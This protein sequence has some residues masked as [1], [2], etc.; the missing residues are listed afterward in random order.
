MKNDRSV[1]IIA[2]LL[3][4]IKPNRPL[5]WLYRELA[6]PPKGELHSVSQFAYDGKKWQTR[7]FAGCWLNL[8]EIF[9]NCK[10]EPELPRIN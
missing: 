8:C 3:Y 9:K 5:K 10:K 1:R 2:C 6:T 7:E 4:I